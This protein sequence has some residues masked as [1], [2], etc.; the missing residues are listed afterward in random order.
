LGVALLELDRSFNTPLPAQ[1][2]LRLR[3]GL[4]LRSGGPAGG[5]SRQSIKSTEKSAIPFQFNRQVSRQESQPGA[6]APGARKIPVEQ[7]PSIANV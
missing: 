3:L 1:Q 4:R 5:F 7:Q 2:K 6:W